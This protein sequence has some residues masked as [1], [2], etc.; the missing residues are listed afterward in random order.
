MQTCQGVKSFGI[1]VV[2]FHANGSFGL[3]IPQISIVLLLNCNKPQQE[4]NDFIWIQVEAYVFVGNRSRSMVQKNKFPIKIVISTNHF[5]SINFDRKWFLSRCFVCMCNLEGTLFAVSGATHL[6]DINRYTMP[7]EHSKIQFRLHFFYLIQRFIGISHIPLHLLGFNLYN[8][9][10]YEFVYLHLVLNI[11]I[12]TFVILYFKSVH[13]H[14]SES[15]FEIRFLDNF[16]GLVP[17]VHTPTHHTTESSIFI[18]TPFQKCWKIHWL[19][20]RLDTIMRS[21]LFSTHM[22]VL[23]IWVHF[24]FVKFNKFDATESYNSL[25]S[26]ANWMIAKRQPVAFHSSST[27]VSLSFSF[28]LFILHCVCLLLL[29]R[30]F[31]SSLVSAVQLNAFARFNLISQSKHVLQFS[32]R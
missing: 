31:S 29:F 26:N 28:F 5:H 18:L 23:D 9:V 30:F 24:S 27:F 14:G 4:R 22:S 15:V 10:L 7:C 13:V 17:V 16:R 11:W 12:A 19:N 25:K 2:L 20:Y 3:S 1:L 8:F 6:L 32:N 21:M